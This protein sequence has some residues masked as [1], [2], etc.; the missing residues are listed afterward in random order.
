MNTKA[1]TKI[2]TKINTKTNLD[3]Y[4]FPD[5]VLTKPDRLTTAKPWRGHIPFA[6]WLIYTLKPNLFVE[7]GTY[8]G[9]SYAAFCQMVKQLHLPTK[10]FS[11][12]TFSGDEHGGLYGNEIYLDI[13]KY[14]EKHYKDFST[15]LPMTFDK[16]LNKFKDGSIDLLHIDGL[17]TYQAVKHDFYT[18]LPKL[19]SNSV[20]L[21]HD[22]VEKR[23]DFGVY[24]FLEEIK[25]KYPHFIFN[26]SHGLGVF[27]IGPKINTYIE[28][29]TSLNYHDSRTIQ[30]YFS[31]ISKRKSFW[32]A[33]T[34]LPV[35]YGKLSYE[36]TKNK[37]K[38][39]KS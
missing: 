18:W 7:L 8:K 33:S 10:C 34:Y 26:H 1:N 27:A 5:I 9:D 29:L 14:N 2:N 3:A 16:A 4:L 24:K 39:K 38:S 6:F 15:I 28:W 11:I 20:V 17:H 22:A 21:F 37:K 13:N 23:D 12:D 31:G 25:D 32:K 19:S 30:D 35:L 36:L